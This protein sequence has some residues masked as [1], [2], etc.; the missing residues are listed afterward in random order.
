MH[1]AA[2]R[3]QLTI[4]FKQVVRTQSAAATARWTAT[5]ENAQGCLWIGAQ[6][7]RCD[8]GGEGKEKN[9]LQR[10]HG[11]LFSDSQNSKC[12]THTRE[13]LQ[14]WLQMMQ[15]GE[16]TQRPS[17]DW[18]QM[19]Q[20]RCNGCHRDL[21]SEEELAAIKTKQQKV[22]QQWLQTMQL[23][24]MYSA[25]DGTHP[26]HSAP[27]VFLAGRRGGGCHP[28]PYFYALLQPNTHSQ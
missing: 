23:G 28:H 19:I 11:A 21:V 20:L 7:S 22:W 12:G 26:S 14:R 16:R 17:T 13:R 10:G 15:I 24:A 6:C 27:S 18:L 1:A 3:R 5:T 9:W 4:D 8:T 25:A 2:N